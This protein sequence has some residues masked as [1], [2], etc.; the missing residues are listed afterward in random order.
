MIC[1]L[2]LAIDFA[3]ITLLNF[4]FL[5]AEDIVRLDLALNNRSLRSL[6]R[7]ALKRRVIDV[8]LAVS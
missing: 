2:A 6:Y 3:E 4:N 5:A 7:N 8:E 1:F